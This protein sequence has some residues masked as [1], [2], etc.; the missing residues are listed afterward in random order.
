MGSGGE[1][2]PC[3]GGLKTS[4]QESERPVRAWQERQNTTEANIQSQL[5]KALHGQSVHS[6][7]SGLSAC[8]LCFD[9]TLI[10]HHILS[11]LLWTLRVLFIQGSCYH[12]THSLRR[13][14]LPDLCL[15]LTV[16]ITLHNN[17]RHLSS[18]TRLWA[19]NN[20]WYVAKSIYW[21]S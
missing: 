9:Y 19:W 14:W 17:D 2:L 5:C 18:P 21:M 6:N 1:E 11:L 20:F 13:T 7:L 3:P 12:T 16:N 8:Q 4:E 10:G 15:L